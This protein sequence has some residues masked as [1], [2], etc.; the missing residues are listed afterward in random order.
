MII[1]GL[2]SLLKACIAPFFI[3]L[4]SPYQP[5]EC[6]WLSVLIPISILQ[7]VYYWRVRGFAKDRAIF[8]RVAE[9]VRHAA[10]F[11]H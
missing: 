2:Y 11:P 1:S 5:V 9:T 3:A 10:Y 7:A 6:A 8:L 4:S